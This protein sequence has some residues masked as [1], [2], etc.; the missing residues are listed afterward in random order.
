M[1]KRLGIILLLLAI[2]IGSVSAESWYQLGSIKFTISAG[3]TIPLTYTS[4][5]TD[6]TDWGPGDG[7]TNFSVGGVGGI[8]FQ[9]YLCSWF[10]LGAELGFQFNLSKN[11]DVFTSVPMLLKFTFNPIQTSRWEFPLSIGFGGN[12]IS[13]E[14]VAKFTIGVTAEFEARYFF[15]DNWGIGLKSGISIIP[16]WYTKKHITGMNRNSL[17]T[18]IPIMLTV[19][20]R[21]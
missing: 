6:E 19:T 14:E 11:S 13:Y 2:M 12:Y 9:V 7:N 10:S 3:P 18:S 4:Y 16:E 20:Y 17:L 5:E 1:K 15:F 21:N 8:D